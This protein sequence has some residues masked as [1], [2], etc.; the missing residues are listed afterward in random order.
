MNNN[1]ITC[2]VSR[3][4][5]KKAFMLACIVLIVAVAAGYYSSYVEQKE[6]QT[7]NKCE[8]IYL[9]LYFVTVLSLC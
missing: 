4:D 5:V 3:A 2:I 8:M 9:I 1:N 7:A 6:L